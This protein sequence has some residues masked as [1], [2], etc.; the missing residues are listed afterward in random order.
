MPGVRRVKRALTPG[1]G[2]NCCTAKFESRRHV[3]TPRAGYLTP[4]HCLV[5][6]SIAR[7]SVGRGGWYAGTIGNA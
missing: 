4:Y 1:G 3:H 6:R 2:T 7:R 5:T